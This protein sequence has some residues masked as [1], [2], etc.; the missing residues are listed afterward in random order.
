VDVLVALTQ[1]LRNLG[2][3]KKI[4]TD[5][6]KGE[7]GED[8]EHHILRAVDWMSDNQVPRD[9]W[10]REFRH[11]LAKW[12]REW[13]EEI[14]VPDDWDEMKKR[15]TDH[16]SKQGRSDQQLHDRWRTLSFNPDTDNIATFISNVRQTAARLEY[17]D[18]AVMNLIKASMP[19]HVYSSLYSINNLEA[20]IAMVKDLFAPKTTPANTLCSMS[21]EESNENPS[22]QTTLINTLKT[23]RD[24]LNERIDEESSSNTHR[25][26]SRN[27]G[28]SYSRNSDRSS[29]RRGHRSSSRPVDNDRCFICHRHGHFQADCPQ[30]ESPN[31]S[32]VRSRSRD[33][34]P[35]VYTMRD[36]GSQYTYQLEPPSH[37]NY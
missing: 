14:T 36:T 16:Y 2:H 13:Y 32:P 21:L 10:P 25:S 6:F 31:Q 1:A 33:N 37:L 20:V 30:N 15:F 26:R 22:G 28:N 7:P 17:N 18:R 11:T 24:F 5:F 23:L 4:C 27:R 19:K 34:G 29:N 9:Q 12:A 3:Q 8:P 35:S